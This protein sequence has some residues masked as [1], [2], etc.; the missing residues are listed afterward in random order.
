MTILLTLCLSIYSIFYLTMVILELRDLSY[1]L[2]DWMVKRIRNV[3]I[4]SSI[5]TVIFA[6]VAIWYII[7]VYPGI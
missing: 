7:A 4:F 2:P 6:A 1:K 3:Q 5:V